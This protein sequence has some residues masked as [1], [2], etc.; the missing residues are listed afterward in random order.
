M[1]VATIH[2]SNYGLGKELQSYT[3]HVHDHL[4]NV[5]TYMYLLPPHMLSKDM[6]QWQ[7]CNYNAIEV[8]V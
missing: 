1:G 4:L 8:Y 7:E 3:V 5:V 2:L 6:H